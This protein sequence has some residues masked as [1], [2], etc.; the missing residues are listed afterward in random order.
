MDSLTLHPNKKYVATAQIGKDPY[1][2]VW[3]VTTTETI[4]LLKGFHSRGI[5]SLGFSNDGKYLASVGLD[6]DHQMA[7]WDWETGRIV[8]HDKAGKERV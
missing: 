8:A 4:A 6:D 5:G 2:A 3:D 7:F 1:I